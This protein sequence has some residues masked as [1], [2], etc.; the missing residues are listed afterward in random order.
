MQ[1]SVH[2]SP[3]T[4]AS[5][6]DVSMAP[7]LHAAGTPSGFD[8]RGYRPVKSRPCRSH[9]WESSV[10]GSW[11]RASPRWRPPP[12]TRSCCAAGARTGADAMVAGLAPSLAKQVEKGK[13]TEEE[14]AAISGRVTRH[15]AP[16]RARRRRPRHRVGRRGPRREEGTSS[17][18]ST[19]SASPTTILATN[20]STLPVVEMADGDRPARP[21]VR[22][23]LLQ[24]GARHG[25]RRGRAA[26]HRQRRH[27]GRGD[28]LRRAPAARTRS[29]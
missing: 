3:P 2:S 9:G 14:A 5:V 27:H 18:S 6:P 23:P 1:P 22:H 28:R 16:R 24:P 7:L 12:G 21:G 10:R 11:A 8:A 15:H 4:R 20:T 19:A 17:P 13:R 26:D 29:R 25:P